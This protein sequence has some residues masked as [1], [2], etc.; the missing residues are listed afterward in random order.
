MDAEMQDVVRGQD[1]R[2]GRLEACLTSLYCATRACCYS[3]FMP[4]RIYPGLALICAGVFLLAG[5]TAP[6]EKK[7]AKTA[8]SAAS[9]GS[10]ADTADYSPEAVERRTEAHARYASAVLH[11]WEEEPELAAADYLKAALADPENESLVLEVSE[12]LLRLKQNDHALELLTKATAQPGAS[13]ALFARLGLLYSLTGKK[14]QAIEANRTSIRKMPGAIAGY[15]HLAQIYFQGS[16][17]DEG[18]KVLDQAAKQPGTD[19]AFLIELAELY[20][21]FIRAGSA[22]AIKPKALALFNRA[23]KLKPANPIL[24]QKLADGLSLVGDSDQAAELYLKLLEHFPALPGLREK[25]VDLYLRKQDRAKAA[26]Q[27]EEIVRQNPT[28]PQAYYVL[29]SLAYEDKKFKEAIEYFNKTL[30]LNPAFQQAYYDLA[31]ALISSNKP[32]DALATLEKAREK[33]SQN[34]V[35]EFFTALAYSRMKE[36]TN[37]IKHFEGAEII[38]RATET[39][40][41]THIFY[42]QLGSTYERIQKLDVAET[43]FRKC[44]AISPDYSEALNYLGYMW[45]EK[46]TNLAEARGMIQKAV[47]LEPKNAAFLDSLAWVLFKLNQPK[48]ALDY[49]LKAVELSEEPDATVYD[50]LGDIREALGQHDEA[51]KAWQKSVSLEDN[52][53]VKRKLDPKGGKE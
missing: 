7:S 37:A 12:R 30:L 4:S 39:N 36:Y 3:I 40:R 17:Y 25:L 50:H 53:Q 44:L 35:S 41:L 5:C 46:G 21:G 47:K 48:E 34:F 43:Y 26:Q 18:L 33:F 16:Q 22:D 1:A 23:A 20:A 45:A 8:A 9:P 14:E 29:G 6:S 32:Q 49:A 11:E 24:L 31:G 13:G 38:A 51:R 10:S 15:R 19:A 52:A 42:Y 2:K 27:L 28:G